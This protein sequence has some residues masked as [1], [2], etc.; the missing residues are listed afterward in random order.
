MYIIFMTIVFTILTG[1][2][3]YSVYYNWF[4]IKKKVFCTKSNTHKETPIWRQNITY[5]WD[6]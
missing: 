6:Q 4:L 5:K 2:T 1:I 3:I